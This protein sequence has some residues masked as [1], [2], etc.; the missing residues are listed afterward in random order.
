MAI[1]LT[2]KIPKTSNYYTNLDSSEVTITLSGVH[3]INWN[4]KK[5]LIKIP[6]YESPQD[7][8]DDEFD[9]QILDLKTIEETCI[10]RAWL[11]D[12]STETAWNKLWKL[13]AMC[14]S[15]NIEGDGGNISSFVLDDLTFDG[16]T[17]RTCFIE[18]LTWTLDKSDPVKVGD[19]YHEISKRH[20]DFSGS[21]IN[22]VARID[23]SLTLFFGRDRSQD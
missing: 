22:D 20:K 23:I 15:G 11:E 17:G 12:D 8:D 2:K 10:I 21:N 13:R 9:V 3:T 7:Q 5:S 14:T 6:N 1:S 18:S 4:I 19:N 16:T